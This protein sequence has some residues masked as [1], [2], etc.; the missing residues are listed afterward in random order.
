MTSHQNNWRIS[1]FTAY[2]AYTTEISFCMNQCIFLIQDEESE[3]Y[4]QLLGKQKEASQEQ[5]AAKAKALLDAQQAEA[6]QSQAKTE[7]QKPQEIPAASS[8][9]PADDPKKQV[10]L[11]FSVSCLLTKSTWVWNCKLQVFPKKFERFLRD[12][13]TASCTSGALRAWQYA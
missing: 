13:N 4:R 3:K 11:L 10:A 5:R 1:Y 2:L 7:S 12:V 6:K 9:E 8:D